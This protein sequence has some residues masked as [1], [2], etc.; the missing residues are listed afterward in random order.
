MYCVNKHRGKEVHQCVQFFDGVD[1]GSCK[2]AMCSAYR[3]HPGRGESPTL[4][5]DLKGAPEVETPEKQDMS[6]IS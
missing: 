6:K 5:G 4:P 1:F 2:L 3:P